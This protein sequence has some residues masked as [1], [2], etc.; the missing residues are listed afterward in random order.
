M[1]EQQAKRRLYDKGEKRFKHEGRDEVPRIEYDSSNPRK[2]IGKCPQAM[3]AQLRQQLL[4]E[5]VPGSPG[6]REVAYAKRLYVVHDGAIYEA[7][8][9]DHG[10]SYHGFPYRGRLDRRMLE[11]LRDMA[12]RKGCLDDFER[13]VKEHIVLGGGR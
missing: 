6:D 13:W 4:S 2:W 8:T 9:S 1:A 12:Q 7:R 11:L 10:R 3:P 5:A